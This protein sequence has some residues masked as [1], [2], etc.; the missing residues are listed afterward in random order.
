MT[1][2]P[3]T[4]L[5]AIV[6]LVVQAAIFVWQWGIVPTWRLPDLMWAVKYDFDLIQIVGLGAAAILA[7]LVTYLV[8]R[9]HPK[10]R[11]Q[12]TSAAS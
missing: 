10:V 11:R 6:T 8:G 12:R 4:L 9:Y 7:P 2:G 1:L 5:V 3:A